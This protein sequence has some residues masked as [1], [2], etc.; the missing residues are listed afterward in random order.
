MAA[1]A[2][3]TSIASPGEVDPGATVTVKVTVRNSGGTTGYL[4]VSGSY[5]GGVVKQNA[6]VT[7][8]RARIGRMDSAT[9][10]VTFAMPSNDTELRLDAWHGDARSRVD[11]HSQEVYVKMPTGALHLQDG[12]SATPLARATSRKGAEVRHRSDFLQWERQILRAFRQ[13]ARQRSQA[14]ASADDW[15]RG[16]LKDADDRLSQ[17][18]ATATKELDRVRKTT[19]RKLGQTRTTATQTLDKAWRT[20]G[21]TRSILNVVGLGSELRQT[22]PTLASGTLPSSI[23]S[24]S[25]LAFYKWTVTADSTADM[26]W[27]YIAFNITGTLYSSADG[28]FQ[29]IGTDDAT[30]PSYDGIY[31]ID[32]GSAVTDTR[33]ISNIKVYNFD[34]GT[35]VLGTNYYRSII[36][37][38]DTGGYYLVFVPTAEEEIGKGAT[39]TYELRG[40]FSIG[41]N[42]TNNS[43]NISTKIADLSSAVATSTYALVA[44][45]NAANS[46]AAAP[47]VSFIWSD[48]STVGHS[49]LTADWTDDY[50]VSGIP[51]SSLPMSK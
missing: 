12:P 26:N 23:L 22:K 49:T 39:K 46:V 15:R 29:T 10:D 4:G 38:A 13:S 20:V 11:D 7:P 42:A 36:T 41:Q 16:K 33:F 3:I 51:T 25:T 30:T 48:R 27:N 5:L 40:D 9:F 37:A 43:G 24:A 50:K 18:R 17:L 19:E 45:A 35:Q 2:E 1:T 47:G 8:K 34:T 14:E 44:G 21:N 31:G 6:L 32:N 28:A